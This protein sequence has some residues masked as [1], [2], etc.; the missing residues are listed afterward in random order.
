M[1]YGTIRVTCP[2]C[3][4]IELTQQDVTVQVCTTNNQGSYTFRCPECGMA[5]SKPAS[6]RIID[7]LVSGGVRLSVWHM[8]A[9]LDE[10][11]NGEPI[12][13]DDILDFHLNVDQEL[14]ELLASH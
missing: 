8:P 10:P 1:G 9:E 2:T 13:H 4:D 7:L 3:G 11:K 12:D 5:T 14:A 6:S